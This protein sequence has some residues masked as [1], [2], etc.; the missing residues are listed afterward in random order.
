MSPIF[1]WILDC[2]G[3]LQRRYPI[4]RSDEATRYGPWTIYFD[5]PPIPVRS[6]DW[7]FVHEDY[8]GAPDGCDNRGGAVATFA[9]AL[10]AC[11]EIEDEASD[12]SEEIRG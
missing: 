7:C 1:E 10:N 11:D 4:T 9:D 3:I 8:D 2:A 12:I 5:P 6:F